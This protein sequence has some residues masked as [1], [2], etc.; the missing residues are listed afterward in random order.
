MS[1]SAQLDMFAMC[2]KQLEG[3]QVKDLNARHRAALTEALEPSGTVTV[4]A[5]PVVRKPYTVSR[6]P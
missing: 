1:Q 3:L 5:S 4:F 2:A 6:Q